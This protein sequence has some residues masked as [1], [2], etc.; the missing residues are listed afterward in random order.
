MFRRRR[1]RSRDR[2][3]GFLPCQ[4]RDREG[5][6]VYTGRNAEFMHLHG[7]HGSM[8]NV[9][10]SRFRTLLLW[11]HNNPVKSLRFCQLVPI[12]GIVMA[13]GSSLKIASYDSRKIML[14]FR[15]EA[16]KSVEKLTVLQ[17]SYLKSGLPGHEIAK[18]AEKP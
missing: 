2:I 16:T 4:S 3:T 14:G 9:R 7:S 12:S 1:Q 13:T 18:N 17:R 5:N 6:E 15:A 8:S 11:R 10:E